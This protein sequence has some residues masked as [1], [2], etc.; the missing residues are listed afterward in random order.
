MLYTLNVYIYIYIHTIIAVIRSG[1][2]AL[3]N[4]TIILDTTAGIPED[5]WHGLEIA[6]VDQ[7]ELERTT[8]AKLLNKRRE[9]RKR[10]NAS[11]LYCYNGALCHRAPLR[12]NYTYNKREHCRCSRRPSVPTV[13]NLF[14]GSRQK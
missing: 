14:L 10:I 4:I 5:N 12:G 9:K 8:S 13:S 11:R 2:R 6:T 1:W 3:N 7:S